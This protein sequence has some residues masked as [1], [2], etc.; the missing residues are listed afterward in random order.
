MTDLHPL[1]VEWLSYRDKIRSTRSRLGLP[2]YAHLCA[3]LR[4]QPSTIKDLMVRAH[5][6]HVAAYRVVM[7]MH[8]M[9][10]LHISGWLTVYGQKSLPVFKFGQGVDAPHPDVRPNGLKSENLEPLPS[11]RLCA[12]VTAWAYLLR[13]IETP[14]RT[15]EVVEETGLN[16]TTVRIALEIMDAL[17]LAHI[18]GWHRRVQGGGKPVPIFVLGPG[19]R[20][21][22]PPKQRRLANSRYYAKTKHLQMIKATAGA[23]VNND[24]LEMA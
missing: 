11:K 9:K 8:A 3:I 4:D 19:S 12:A 6:G 22:R 21:A 1:T 24:E 5:L 7:A 15:E 23:A 14:A 16:R 18:C 10:I 17:G 13:A 20:A 2:G